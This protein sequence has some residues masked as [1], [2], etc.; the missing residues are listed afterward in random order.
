MKLHTTGIDL[1]DEDAI[2]LRCIEDKIDISERQ[3]ITKCTFFLNERECELVEAVMKKSQFEDY[4]LYGG[5][6][7]SKRKIF[8]VFPPYSYVNFSDLP[9]RCITFEYRRE[10]KLTHRDFLGKFMSLN[11][12][13]KTIGDIL[14]S[15]GKTCAFVYETVY[16]Q[17]L[18]NC[19]KI[20]RT[21]VKVSEGFDSSLA[22]EQRFSEING[23]VASLRADCIISL[24]TGLSREKSVSLIRKNGF[25]VNF[26]EIF[27]PSVKLDAN[28]VF[29]VKGY[30]KFIFRSVNG[31]SKKDRIH[32][33]ICKFL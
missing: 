23:T 9:V 12:E 17:I 1:S 16:D 30:G 11:V 31:L 25:I 4:T 14:V 7:N 32:I 29:S 18:Y 22:V 2:L 20:G 8:A 5:Y 24:A 15:E 3:F 26:K 13:R 28:D 33:T 10:D 21:G 6:D 19:S 27:S